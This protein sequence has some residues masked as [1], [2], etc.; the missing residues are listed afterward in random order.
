MWAIGGTYSHIED[1]EA[2]LEEH[3]HADLTLMVY[4][5]ENRPEL[6]FKGTSSRTVGPGEAV[7]IRADTDYNTS[8]PELA[9]VLYRGEVVGNTI[10]NDMS[11]SGLLRENPLYLAATKVFS[12]C[13]AVGSAV[14]SAE[15]IDDPHD[16]EIRMTVERGG[17]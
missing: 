15:S 17:T 6:F 11:A 4:D 13:C 16:L 3:D 9:L 2:F 8:E 5:P 12:R 10:G 7:G 14:V 1:E